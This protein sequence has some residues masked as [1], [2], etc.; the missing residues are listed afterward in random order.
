[1]YF[2]GAVSVSSCLIFPDFWS[3]HRVD[4]K[5]TLKVLEWTIYT[6]PLKSY[7]ILGD[8]ENNTQ[9]N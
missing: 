9:F 8:M 7:V 1:M 6:L 3:K 5:S 2:Y 4:F